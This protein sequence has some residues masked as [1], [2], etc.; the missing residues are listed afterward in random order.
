MSEEEEVDSSSDGAV[1]VFPDLED[2][3][4]KQIVNTAAHVLNRDLLKTDEVEDDLIAS[5]IHGIETPE[6]IT[7]YRAVETRTRNRD[8]VH[9]LLDERADWLREHGFRPDDL[10]A[11][12]LDP[13]SVLP[14]RF[15]MRIP[16]WVCTYD[17]RETPEPDRDRHTSTTRRSQYETPSPQTSSQTTQVTLADGGVDDE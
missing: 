11:A 15:Q 10:T 3:I 8:R 7:A 14:E 13:E 5:R 4:G 12:L 17:L 1:L 9:E 16:L 6:E 2:R